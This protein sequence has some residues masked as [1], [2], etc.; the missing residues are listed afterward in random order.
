MRAV[1]GIC[2]FVLAVVLPS[3]A[4][5]PPRKYQYKI[6]SLALAEQKNYLETLLPGV[7]P[8]DKDWATIK[9]Y[10]I[11]T[12]DT[13]SSGGVNCSTS[14][15]SVT[16]QAGPAAGEQWY[17]TSSTVCREI[18]HSGN[19]TVLGMSNPKKSSS[20]YLLLVSC[21]REYTDK[22]KALVIGTDGVGALFTHKGYCEMQEPGQFGAMSL[23]EYKPGQ[24]LVYVGTVERL[25]AK[26][27]LSK[28]LVDEVK[29]I[30]AEEEK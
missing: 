18:I 14:S 29:T 13:Q 4:Q 24:F 7:K 1:A 23:E 6:E 2:I 10:I 5:A 22:Q 8:G 28:Y 26:P 9:P 17:G 11:A 12:Q 16:P 25:G 30:E 3:A 19:V 15:S 20:G 27:K 21:A